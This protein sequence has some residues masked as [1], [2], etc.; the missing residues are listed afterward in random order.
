[1][2]T[3]DTTVYVENPDWFKKK[4][5]KKLLELKSH[6]EVVRCRINVQ[7]VFVSLYTVN[8]QVGI[9]IEN[10]IPFIFAYP[11]MKYL[12][13]TLIKY[14]EGLYI[15]KYKTLMKEIKVTK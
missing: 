11:T 15:E 13:I 14:A 6:T 7:K 9:E 4:K 2:F 1:M 5:H 10:L 12:G 3:D 8:E